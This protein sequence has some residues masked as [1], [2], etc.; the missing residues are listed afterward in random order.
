M[1]LNIKNPE[2]HKLAAELAKQTGETMTCAVTQALRE[3]LERVQ[4]RRKPDATVADLLAIGRR[5]AS[6]LKGKPID[7]AQLLYDDRGIPR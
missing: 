2:T 1:T 7:H 5:C 6:T 4:R 3:R